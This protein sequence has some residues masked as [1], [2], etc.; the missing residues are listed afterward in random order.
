MQGFPTYSGN[1]DICAK[2]GRV[3]DFATVHGQEEFL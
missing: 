3:F 1:M 2:Y